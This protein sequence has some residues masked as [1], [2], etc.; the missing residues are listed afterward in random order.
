MQLIGFIYQ[1]RNLQWNILQRWYQ[2]H[3]YE[4]IIFE[5]CM[6]TPGSNNY[7][8][9]RFL[10]FFVFI[11]Q[12][13]YHIH[14][15]D[16]VSRA[17]ES[18]GRRGFPS[19][20]VPSRQAPTPVP[21][22]V[23]WNQG[24]IPGCWNYNCPSWRQLRQHLKSETQA[25]SYSGWGCITKVKGQLYAS[26]SNLWKNDLWLLKKKTILPV[27]DYFVMPLDDFKAHFVISCPK[28]GAHKRN[29]F[30]DFGCQCQIGNLPPTLK[31]LFWVMYNICTW[32]TEVGIFKDL[33]CFYD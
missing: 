23:C 28:S 10:T 26:Y 20:G 19:L 2:V 13:C 14:T 9:D 29:H 32:N 6:S 3:W 31:G 11:F 1:M 30:P 4:V 24:A 5:R 27:K 33:H 7:F 12:K 22:Q 21:P 18:T 16:P 15:R 25:R 17:T 8:E